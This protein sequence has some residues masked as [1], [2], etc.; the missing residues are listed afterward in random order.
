MKLESF[1]ANLKPSALGEKVSDVTSKAADK[2]E[3]AATK[4]EAQALNTAA[5]IG[6]KLDNSKLM[7]SVGQ[8]LDDIKL[9]GTNIEHSIGKT[10][11]SLKPPDDMLE[12]LSEVKNVL[13]GRACELAKSAIELSQGLLSKIYDKLDAAYNPDL[14]EINLYGA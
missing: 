10:F 6:D 13:L 7:D 2:L 11:D 3:S 14:A 4:L 8:K 12:K 9:L 5:N 1:T